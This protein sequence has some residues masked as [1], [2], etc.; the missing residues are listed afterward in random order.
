MR[1]TKKDWWLLDTLF[2]GQ[3]LRRTGNGS[4]SITWFEWARLKKEH[5]PI[6]SYINSRVLLIKATQRILAQGICGL[7]KLVFEE[8]LQGL[9]IYSIFS[10]G[11]AGH[12]SLAAAPGQPVT[13][14]C[15]GYSALSADKKAFSPW[16]SCMVWCLICSTP[17]GLG[18]SQLWAVVWK[19]AGNRGEELHNLRIW[20]QI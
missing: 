11:L 18:T 13:V 6:S 19:E 8:R 1:A 20:C 16:K 15:W 17:A 10:R 7:K 12:C 14:L 5:N 9:Q 3:L 2:A 4:S